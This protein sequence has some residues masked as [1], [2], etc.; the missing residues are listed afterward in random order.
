MN[1]AGQLATGQACF[2]HTALPLWH[3]QETQGSFVGWNISPSEY[4][5]PF[6]EQPGVTKKL[7]IKYSLAF[8]WEFPAK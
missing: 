8:K 4:V 2:E 7:E 6:T 1:A 3:V 5:S